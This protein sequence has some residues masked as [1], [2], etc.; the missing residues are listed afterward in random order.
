MG[1]RSRDETQPKRLDGTFKK[2]LIDAELLVGSESKD[3]TLYSFRHFYAS[4]E[5]LREPPITIYLLA[6]QMGTSVKMI[7]HHYGHMEAYQKADRLSGWK[8]ID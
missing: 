4:Q 2:F 5:L 3:R 1:E 8:D 6:K 7:E